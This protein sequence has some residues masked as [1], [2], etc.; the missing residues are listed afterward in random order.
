MQNGKKQVVLH[1][2]SLARLTKSKNKLK[3]GILQHN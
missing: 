1:V 3:N 2:I